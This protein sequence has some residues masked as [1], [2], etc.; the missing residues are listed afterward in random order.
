MSAKAC[1]HRIYIPKCNSKR[2][3]QSKREPECYKSAS[4]ARNFVDG[5]ICELVTL[6]GYFSLALENT[7]CKRRYARYP[8][9]AENLPS[10]QH[11]PQKGLAEL[12]SR[13][14][15][16]PS[17]FYYSRKALR[18]DE[19]SAHIKTMKRTPTSYA[20]FRGE[21]HAGCA[22]YRPAQISNA[23]DRLSSTNEDARAIAAGA[24]T[25]TGK[26]II[27]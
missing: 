3:L 17:C 11:F 20:K 14:C 5:D 22:E 26:S 6:K 27:V 16:I 7:R 9:Y 12:D 2:A 10:T 13:A 8:L 21:N 23:T 18:Q 4:T 1:P 15:T 25:P 19:T 24:T